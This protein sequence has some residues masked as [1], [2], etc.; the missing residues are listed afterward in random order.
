M[1]LL[2]VT[3]LLTRSLSL[4]SPCPSFISPFIILDNSNLTATAL[5]TV[6]FPV[7]Y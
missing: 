5:A 2:S 3:T 1:E 7:A 6:P 4:F